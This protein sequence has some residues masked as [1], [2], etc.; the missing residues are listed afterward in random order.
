MGR[1]LGTRSCL[2]FGVKGGKKFIT[3][4]VACLILIIPIAVVETYLRPLLYSWVYDLHPY[5]FDGQ[6]RYFGFRPLAFFENG[7]QYGIWVAATALAAVWQMEQ[8]N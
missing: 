3:G 8:R 2:L 5:R 6:E 1:T 4:L 7:N